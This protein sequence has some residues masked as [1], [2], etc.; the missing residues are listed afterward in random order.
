MAHKAAVAAIVVGMGVGGYDINNRQSIPALIMQT[1]SGG[2]AIRTT[3]DPTGAVSSSESFD[4]LRLRIER[5]F[6][7]LEKCVGKPL[8]G[9]D[10][11]AK[12]TKE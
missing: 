7:E 8:P 4:Q 2:S 10:P 12:N 6:S 3:T 5:E 9:L 11:P 1:N